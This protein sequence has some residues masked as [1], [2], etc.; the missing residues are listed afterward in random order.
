MKI[1][2]TSIIGQFHTNHNEDALVIAELSEKI[3]LFAVMDG[4]SMGTESHFASILIGKVLRKIAKEISFKNFVEKTEKSLDV[5]LKEILQKLFKCLNELKNLLLLEKE[6]LLSTLILG[7]LDGEKRQ[8]AI[9]TIGDGLICCNGKYVEYEQD[10]KPDYLAYHL[11]E[12]FDVWF[13]SQRQILYCKHIYDLSI[14]TDGIFSFK[15]FDNKIYTLIQENALIDLLLID[16]QWEKQKNMLSR[17]LLEIER[18][19]G[20]KP[21]DDLSIVRILLA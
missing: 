14:A 20:L 16:K 18:K 11:Q 13:K 1:Y 6:E 19:F 17:K 3:K 15:K 7:V 4:C 10:N 5:H 21:S 2:Q 9:I 12:K 8:A